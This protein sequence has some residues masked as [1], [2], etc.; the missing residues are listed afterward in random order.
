[1]RHR[2][3]MTVQAKGPTASPEPRRELL[4]VG[5]GH[6]HVQVLRRLGMAPLPRCRV[7]LVVDRPVAVYSGMVPGFV[8]GEYPASALEID[9]RPLARR[10]GVRLVVAAAERLDL[11]ARALHVADRP[12]IPFDL[13]SLNIGSEVAGAGLPGVRQHAYL[14]RPI[15]EFVASINAP[16]E[17]LRTR[18]G[19]VR[20]LVVGAGAGG[21]ELAFCMQAR[22]KA[23]GV[24]EVEVTLV[25]RTPDP[26][27]GATPAMVRA[28]QSAAQGRGVRLLGGVGVRAVEAGQAFL[29]EGGALPFDLLVWVTGAVASPFFRESGLPTD[30]RGFVRVRDT[31]EVVGVDG[32]FAVGDCA[33]PDGWP[34]IPKAGVYAVRQ[35]PVLDHNLR[36]RLAGR[37]L[38]PYRPQRD[39]L[40]L[41]NLGDGTAI[42]GRSG[43]AGR[44]RWLLQWKRWIDQ[45]FMDRFQ[46]LCPDGAPS[47][48]FE[49]GDRGLGRP[50]DGELGGEM[51]CGG[52]AAKVG[53]AELHEAL[54]RL[55]LR[56]PDDSVLLGLEAPDDVAV[57]RSLGGDAIV[58]SVDL[59][60]AFTD[61]P[62][63]VGQVAAENALSDLYAKGA[64]PT[65]ALALVT[66]PLDEPRRAELLF[67][68]LSGV[69]RALDAASVSLIGGHSTLGETLTVGLSV[70][71]RVSGPLYPKGGL[72]T[73][74]RLI[75]TRALGT[76]VLWHADQAGRAGGRA[77]GAAIAGMV[78]GNRQTAEHLAGH[79]VTGVTDVTGF[80]L[81]GH[82]GE[83]VRASGRSALVWLDRL[84]A[85]DSV[86]VLLKLGERSTFH[87]QN[88]SIV[89]AISV[90]PELIGHPRLELL[91]D[92]QT[93]GGLLIGIH[94]RGVTPLLDALHRAGERDA[95]EVGEVTEARVDG[96]LFALAQGPRGD[97][98]NSRSLLRPQA[99]TVI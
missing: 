87:T 89:R 70:T 36:A 14:T 24:T 13:V 41:L 73:G 40:A 34:Q 84:P 16:L 9:L 79:P 97:N 78:R 55:P 26:L 44:G 61:D 6:S 69:R 47:P 81:A 93:A 2:G 80:G 63:L 72:Q 77:V 88:R 48:R 7:T 10:A 39:F 38:R 42:G 19:P 52:C 32:V 43:I 85:I 74:D 33:V 64:Q 46:A 65:H 75:L 5:G 58:Q 20:L 30:H 59:F 56:P 82:L 15:G 53:A 57:H 92:P 86:E 68:V 99:P 31:L 29:E 83:M 71:G 35:G 50:M 8:A 95:A 37:S 67:Q 21:V 60:T 11:A 22:M 17:G 90:P 98:G 96:A 45:R 25:S 12:P 54:G 4:L 51:I 76:G 28:V 1:M 18:G 49:G 62:F 3:K 94:P 66:L 27:P 23:L 91:F